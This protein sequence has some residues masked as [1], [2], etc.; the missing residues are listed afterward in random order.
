MKTLLDDRPSVYQLKR[1]SDESCTV[2][3]DTVLAALKPQP[4]AEQDCNSAAFD[5]IPV[6]V[7]LDWLEATS[8]NKS[9]A[10]TDVCSQSG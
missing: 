7:V 5:A 2:S 9:L 8:F 10:D 3:S 4:D 6:D 1:F